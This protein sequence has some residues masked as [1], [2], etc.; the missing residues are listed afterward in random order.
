MGRRK[1]FAV[2]LILATIPLSGYGTNVPQI[3]EFWEGVDITGDMEYRIKENIFCETVHALRSVRKKIIVN[4]Q[5]SIPDS[6]GV[7][8][9]ISLTVEE[10]GG[11][12]PGVALNHTL[13]NAIANKVT[14]PQSFT[15]SA[16]GTLSSTATRTDTSYSYYTIT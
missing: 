11:L 4:G 14:V 16:T 15:L 2:L 1:P 3:Q 12:N 8:M 10:V 13:P 9:Q 5:P 6:Y 7:Q